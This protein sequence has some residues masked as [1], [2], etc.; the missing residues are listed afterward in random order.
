MPP[1]VLLIGNFLRGI[2]HKGSDLSLAMLHCLDREFMLCQFAVFDWPF[3][4]QP[5]VIGGEDAKQANLPGKAA[6]SAYWIRYM[7]C[8]RIPL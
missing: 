3:R 1:E 8:A 4:W 6:P 5:A 2:A 7:V